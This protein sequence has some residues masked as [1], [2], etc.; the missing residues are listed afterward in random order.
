MEF[1]FSIQQ[2]KHLTDGRLLN[3]INQ[4]NQHKGT[5]NENCWKKKRQWKCFL[6]LLQTRRNTKVCFKFSLHLYVQSIK[7]DG[8]WPA[9]ANN[10]KYLC[11]WNKSEKLQCNETHAHV[12]WQS[13]NSCMEYLMIPKLLP[14]F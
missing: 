4:G 11:A 1:H 6:F 8:W 7:F 12:T 13:E 9:P 2:Q 14:I 10:V 3:E 5:R